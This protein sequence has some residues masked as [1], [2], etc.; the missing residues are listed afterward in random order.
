MDIQPAERAKI[1]ALPPRIEGIAALAVNIS[2]SW[3]RHARALF[4]RIDPVAWHASAHNP[5]AMLK[6]VPETRFEA[7]VRDPDFLAHYDKVMEWLAIESTSS[8]G[9]F[10]E[11]YPE[12]SI[13]RPV[14]YFCA[15]FGLHSSVPIYSG[16]LGVLA[17]D[18]IKTASDLALPLVGIG[19]FYKKGYFDQHVRPDGWQEDGDDQIDPD[20]TPLVPVPASNGHDWHTA[21]NT[22]GR[23]IYIRAWTMTVGRTPIY[24]LDTDLEDNHPDDRGLTSKLYAG[25]IPMRLRQE[26]VLGVGGVQVLRA[27]GI[28]PAAWHA[29]EG[30]AAFMMM[31]RTREMVGNGGEFGT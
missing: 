31:E 28:D 22:A 8:Q 13:E 12:V 4:R 5:I 10:R 21:I 20:L 2:W 23:T 16:G 26:W 1:P 6:Q 3:H 18:H 9:W 24:L 14:A 19:L 27:L 15:E 29:N 30:H 7:L 17:G 25:G 11:I